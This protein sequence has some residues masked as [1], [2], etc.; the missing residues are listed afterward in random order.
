MK[1][2]FCG[3]ISV[4]KK[5]T[6]RLF[7]EQN[8][9]ALFNDVC[10]E[11]AKADRV[12]ANLECAVTDKDTP[13]KKLGPNLKTPFGTIEALKKAGVTDCA[14]SNNHIFDFGKPGLEDTLAELE[15]NGIPYTGIGKNAQDARKDM[16]I[17]MEGKKVAVIN[18]CDHEYSYAL[19]DRVGAREFDPFETADDIAEAKK[20]ADYVILVYHGGKEMCRYPSPRQVKMC[21]SMVR[22]GADVVLCQH[23]HCVGCYEEFEGGHI[24]YG[25]GN[26]HFVWEGLASEEWNE[27]LIV[28][29]DLTDGC[30]VE[31]IPTRVD[32]V[33]IR[34]ANE[35][36]KKKTLDGIA[37]RSKTLVDGSY[38]E[39]FGAFCRDP[40]QGYYR[41]VEKALPASELE[42][43]A[44]YLDCEAHYDVWK[45]LYKTYN[46]VNEKE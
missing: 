46:H 18:V 2:M 6:E 22:R 4:N 19:E 24:L 45:E 8:A 34:L 40:K 37:E 16:I 35:E 14:L 7:A 17:E 20:R 9:E 21:R 5:E 1:L 38:K 13:I 15:K 12:I 26:F 39:H 10:G 28:S 11:L 30:K 36:E 29:V 23:T 43:F 33:G 27:G 31:L 3:D 42:R 41:F 25:Q 44:H 32:G